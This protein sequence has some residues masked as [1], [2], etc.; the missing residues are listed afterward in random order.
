MKWKGVIFDMDGTITIPYL[1]FR[2]IRAELGLPSG[3]LISEIEH[4][5]ATRRSW[6]WRVIEGHELRAMENQQVREGTRELLAECR[7]HGIRIGLLTRNSRASVDHLCRRFALTFD[8]AITREFH[9]VKP[10]PAPVLHIVAAWELRV[11]DVLVVGDY[12]HDIECGRRAG[13]HTCFFRTP[14]GQDYSSQADHSV[15]SMHEL[16]ELILDG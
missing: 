16:R 11:T 9:A 5:D 1:D 8:A 14:A 4:L 13:A 6:A 3:D 15:A 2:A 7:R 10:D 12:V